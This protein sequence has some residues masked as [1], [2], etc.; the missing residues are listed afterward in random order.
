MTFCGNAVILL[1]CEFS[2]K[3][4]LNPPGIHIIEMSLV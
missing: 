4:D 2:H 1:R 3:L